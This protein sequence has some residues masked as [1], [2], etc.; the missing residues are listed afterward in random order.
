MYERSQSGNTV[1]LPL[2]SVFCSLNEGRE[3]RK[4]EFVNDES[5]VFISDQR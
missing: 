1:P 2:I 3:K 5:N 4:K